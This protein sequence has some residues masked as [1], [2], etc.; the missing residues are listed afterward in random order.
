MIRLSSLICSGLLA[1]S[2]ATALAADALPQPARVFSER[3]NG[4]AAAVKLAAMRYAAFW[5]TGDPRYA[6]LALDPAFMDRTLP[7]GRPQGVAGPLQASRTFRAAVPDLK[8]E[9]TD[10][11]LADDRVAL[12]L[13]FTGHFSG[14]FGDRQGDGQAID[15]QAF[16]LYRVKNGRIAENWHLEDN[17]TL[18]KQLG[19]VKP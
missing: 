6:E 11:V 13:H 17:L 12:R 1:L 8:V 9:V 14:R 16:D 2:S 10:M 15:F 7:E 19:V 18:L 4:A 5:N 3:N